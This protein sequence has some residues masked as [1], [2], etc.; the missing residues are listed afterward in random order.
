MPLCAKDYGVYNYAD[1]NT[2]SYACDSYDDLVKTLEMC[3]DKLTEWFT[4]NGMQAN[5]EKYQAIVFG[6]K[7]NIPSSF[8]IKGEMVK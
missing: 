6:N 4:A 2:V 5:P 1:D 8:G 3:G 7:P